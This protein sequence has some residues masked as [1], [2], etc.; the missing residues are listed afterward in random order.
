MKVEIK[1]P[2]NNPARGVGDCPESVLE[3]LTG[4]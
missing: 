1:D 4:I 3:V 2:I